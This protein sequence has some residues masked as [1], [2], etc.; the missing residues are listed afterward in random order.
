M[1]NA[2][3][4]QNEIMKHIKK[5]NEGREKRNVMYSFTTINGRDIIIVTTDTY[6]A[7]CFG[8]NEF[9]LDASK[10]AEMNG[11]RA[12]VAENELKKQVQIYP[13]GIIKKCKNGNAVEFV[14]KTFKVYVNE[15]FIKEFGNAET[16]A[17]YS[18]GEYNPVYVYE[19]D[20]LVGLIM[21]ISPARLK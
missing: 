12:F 3:K 1:K 2:I 16:L 11:L 18:S 14:Y 7:Y 20:E 6:M 19:A 13:S 10:M 9:Y 17:F 15:K 5:Y 8:T 4:I 21:P